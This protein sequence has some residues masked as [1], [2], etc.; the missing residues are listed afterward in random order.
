MKISGIKKAP[1]FRRREA[2]SLLHKEC[3]YEQYGTD[4]K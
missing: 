1:Y 3:N 2:F 4:R